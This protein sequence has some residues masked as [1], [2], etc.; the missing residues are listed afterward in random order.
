MLCDICVKFPGTHEA[1]ARRTSAPGK[2]D[3][4]ETSKFLT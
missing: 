3:T 4:R 2:L 1:D